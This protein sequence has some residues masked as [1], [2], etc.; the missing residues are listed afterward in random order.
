MGSAVP[1]AEARAAEALERAASVPQVLRTTCV[2]LVELLDAR[3]CAISRVI[4]D[5]LVALSEH[6][7]AGESLQL[8]QGFLVTDYPLTQD[9]IESGESRVVSLLD[10]E[11]DP[12]EAS[13][14]EALGFNSLLMVSMP[15][16][17]RCWA[18]VEI[19]LGGQATFPPEH[20]KLAEE[21]VARAGALVERFS[22]AT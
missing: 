15:V 20:V 7:P 1:E 9:V 12:R 11:P 14:L 4:G 5:V 17:G 19:Y 18:L 22:L 6:A 3:A 16:E 8:G 2:A 13:L 21:V 10:D